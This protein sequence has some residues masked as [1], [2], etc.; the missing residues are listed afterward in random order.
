MPPSSGVLPY[1]KT[2]FSLFGKEAFR[3]RVKVEKK[4]QDFW[5]N[6]FCYGVMEAVAVCILVASFTCS[7]SPNCRGEREITE[8]EMEFSFGPTHSEECSTRFTRLLV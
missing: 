2:S 1:T 8:Q 7:A 3:S 5:V 4:V 6:I